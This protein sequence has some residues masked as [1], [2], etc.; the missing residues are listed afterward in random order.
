M[1]NI[2]K[3]KI[4][5]PFVSQTGRGNLSFFLGCASMKEKLYLSGKKYFFTESMMNFTCDIQQMTFRFKRCISN[6]NSIL[7]L[8]GQNL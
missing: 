4:T 3:Y 1:S 2:N 7:N 8:M 6:S 5:Y